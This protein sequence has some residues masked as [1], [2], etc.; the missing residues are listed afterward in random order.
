MNALG[1][2]STFKPPRF[3]T[4]PSCI[5]NFLNFSLPFTLLS[6]IRYAIES[7]YRVCMCSVLSIS[8]IL[9]L[10]IQCDY[11]CKLLSITP[12]QKFVLTHYLPIPLSCLCIF[13]DFQTSTFNSLPLSI[14]LSFYPCTFS[15]YRLCL[16]TNFNV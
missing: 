12:N 7:G 2:K 15:N 3:N 13:R 5:H 11:F 9:D 16:H 1:V 8:K 10:K 4:F 14:T 6:D